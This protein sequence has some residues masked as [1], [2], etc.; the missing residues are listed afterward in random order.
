MDTGPLHLEMEI[1]HSLGQLGDPL[2]W[3]RGK[4]SHQ[5]LQS[6]WSLAGPKLASALSPGHWILTILPTWE[7]ARGGSAGRH[8]FQ[9]MFL[10]P[11][12]SIQA[13]IWSCTVSVHTAFL[14]QLFT[15]RKL[16]LGLDQQVVGSW[17]LDLP[18]QCGYMPVEKCDLPEEMLGHD[19]WKSTCPEQEQCTWLP[20]LKPL[21]VTSHLLATWSFAQVY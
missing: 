7:R 4:L 10:R 17:C 2:G 14:K 5:M 1:P 8:S 13:G 11:L 21:S 12:R 3:T 15:L 9:E 6:L 16:H 20:G 19:S 18:H